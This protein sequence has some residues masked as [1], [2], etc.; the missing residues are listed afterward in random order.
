MGAGGIWGTTPPPVYSYKPMATY[1][2][3]NHHTARWLPC[4]TTHDHS[5]IYLHENSDSREVRK[6][7]L[8]SG[9]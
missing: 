7:S 1:I 2:M 8:I 5:Q 3:I 9:R 4:I 6:G